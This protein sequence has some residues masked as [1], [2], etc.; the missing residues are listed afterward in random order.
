M[1]DV[2]RTPRWLAALTALVLAVLLA[3][4]GF[5]VIIGAQNFARIGV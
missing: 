3:A 5:A 1:T 4:A 2:P